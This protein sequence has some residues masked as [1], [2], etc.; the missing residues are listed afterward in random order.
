MKAQNPIDDEKLMLAQRAFMDA[1]SE[2]NGPTLSAFIASVALDF[3]NDDIELSLM[4]IE[5][6]KVCVKSMAGLGFHEN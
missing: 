6:A 3:T 4:I 5:M 1:P 2:M